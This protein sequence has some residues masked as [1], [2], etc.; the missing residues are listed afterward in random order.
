MLASRFIYQSR[1]LCNCGDLLKN[2]TSALAHVIS[3]QVS[4]CIPPNSMAVPDSFRRFFIRFSTALPFQW[5]KSSGELLEM[6]TPVRSYFSGFH[7][8]RLHNNS[9]PG[10][11]IFNIIKSYCYEIEGPSHIW[12]N[13]AC[14]AN[15]FLDGEGMFLILVNAYIEHDSLVDH[16]DRILMIEGVKFLQKRYSKLNVIGLQCVSSAKSVAIHS[17]VL[18]TIMDEYITFPILIL[19]RNSM[20]VTDFAVFLFSEGSTSPPLCIKSG[21]G[22]SSIQ[23]AIDDLS[24]FQKEEMLE[25]LNGYRTSQYATIE[26]PTASSF[27]RNLL[28]SYEVSLSVDENGGR[29]FLSDCNHHRIIVADADGKILDSIG[30]SPG[31]VDADFEA[32]K[33][34]RPA[35]SFFNVLDGCLYFVDSENN[36]IRRA[37]MERRLVETVYPVPRSSGTWSQILGVWNRILNSLE[38]SKHNEK[39]GELDLY[40][41][42]SPWHLLNSG[43]D[44]LI[45]ISHSFAVAWTMSTTTWKVKEVIRGLLITTVPSL[46]SC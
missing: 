44:E 8:S 42:A 30:S 21:E 22:L 4:S 1:K 34:C 16:H 13:N 2:C 46:P 17:E 38:I 43:D 28:L 45:I 23:K 19:D 7:L 33:L 24:S 9:I 5:H 25:E 11:E 20:K 29:I 39:A 37:D 3:R 6:M 40:P 31:F 35:G 41:I 14:N 27:L 32:V 15:K 18:K 10:K 26:E 36:A 12:L